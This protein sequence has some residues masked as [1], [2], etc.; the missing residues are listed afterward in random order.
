MPAT[1]IRPIGHEDRLS[2]IE[3]LDE[4][5]TR[6][7]V[8]LA[9]L[10]VAFAVCAVFNGSLLSVLNKPLEKTTQ[11][12]TKKGNGLPGQIERGQQS[13]RALATQ[14]SAA[15]ATLAQRESGLPLAQRRE[16][17]AQ[18]QKIQAAI[19]ALPRTEGNKPV[20]L[21]V[22]EPFT[23]TL[24]VAFYFALLFSLPIILYQL[25]AFVL[26]AFS[27]RERRVALPLMT[28]IPFLFA[29]GVV[30]GYFVVLPAATK[31][32][33][34]FNADQFNVLVQAR[35]YYKFA[36][37]TLVSIGIVFQLPVGVLAVTRLGLVSV[38]TL[39]RNRRYAIVINAV[40][41][42]LLPGTDP[43]SML[44]EFAIL[45][46]LYEVSVAVA[47]LLRTQAVPED[48]WPGAEVDGDDLS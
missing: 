3:H 20:T 42:M 32:L 16:L 41:A 36:I 44:L 29:A 5:R 47:A 24:S 40:I 15:L 23:T 30:F 22:G 39:R 14:M 34:N 1:A 13:L 26:P 18:R 7:I 38:E 31:F 48:D 11:A 9:T 27:P 46:A 33:Q 10:A 19:R 43:V 6:L 35:D 45:H 8:C 17:Q 21:R 25:Y 12:S 37:L 28:M 2:L 4:L